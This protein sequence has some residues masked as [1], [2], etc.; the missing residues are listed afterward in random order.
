MSFAE[1]PANQPDHEGKVLRRRSPCARGSSHYSRFLSSSFFLV[2][3][4]ECNP[5]TSPSK[6][7]YRPLSL[8][9]GELR[10]L[11]GQQPSRFRSEVRRS[12]P[13]TETFERL[14]R[15]ESVDS[16]PIIR[17]HLLLSSRWS[18]IVRDA[19]E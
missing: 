6:L 7:H 13:A 17:R 12:I 3:T 15:L 16:L 9:H 4:V 18:A 11:P 19:C 10:G 8:P 1:T 14:E 5:S 2:F